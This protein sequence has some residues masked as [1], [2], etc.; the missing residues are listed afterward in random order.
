MNAVNKTGWLRKTYVFLIDG[1]WDIELTSLSWAKRIGVAVVRV[2]QLVFKGFYENECQLHASA[3]TYTSLMAI[4]PI[5]AF[6]TA[7][8]R[9]LGAG[10][11]AEEYILVSIQDMPEQF[12][13]FVGDLLKQVENVNFSMLGGVALLFLLWMVVSVFSQV[14]MSFNRVWGV[15]SPRSI[16][17]RFSDYLSVLVI[18]PVLVIAATTF[19]ATLS[20]HSVFQKLIEHFG[21]AAELYSA[22]LKL[23]PVVSTWIAFVF[24]Y[25][26]MPNTGVRF[27]PALFSGILG[28]SLWILWQRLYI[29]LQVG[30]SRYNAIYAT[31]ASV[32]IFLIW[33][34][35]SWQL[36]LLGAEIGFALQNYRTYKMEQH[37]FG[38]SVEARILLA[39]SIISHG[40]IAMRNKRPFLTI[41]DY[42][43]SH[44]VPVRLI[45]EVVE[46]LVRSRLLARVNDSMDCYVLLRSPARLKAKDVIDVMIKTGSPP[47]ALGVDH[48]DRG[49][50]EI[51]GKADEASS[52]ALSNMNIDGLTE[53]MAKRMEEEKRS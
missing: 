47:S 11:A 25:K 49:V 15:K 37:S 35:I 7:I 39:L 5:L 29:V 6:A 26:F 30:V 38:A 41:S 4:V 36:V 23:A 3:L 28:G 1:I 20:S 51:F 45:N 50:M 8:L 32:P 42:A 44:Q 46:T 34:Y 27:V 22:L 13:S 19:N 43:K 53:L 24:L 18:V 10:K 21:P 17:R 14:E 12:Q 31:F 52:A 9:G 48:V 16:I 40:A 2:L 33:L